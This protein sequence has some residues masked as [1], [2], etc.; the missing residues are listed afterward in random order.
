MGRIIRLRWAYFRPDGAI[1]R[2]LIAVAA[3][4][5]GQYLIASASWI[6]LIFLLGQ[7]SKEVTAGYTIAIRVMIFTILPCWGMANAAATLVGQNLGAGQP[8]R[9][10]RSA[11]RAGFFNL[12]FM[13][14][15]SLTTLITAPWIIRLFTTDPH[16]IEAGSLALRI[17]ASGYVFYG[18]GMIFG[19]AIN[20]AGDT[21]TPTLL[22]FIFFWLIETPL[23]WLLALGIGWGQVGVYS[24]IVLAESGLALA[25]MWV[26]SKGW[27]KKAKV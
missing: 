24:S 15:V 13:A 21:R 25:A 4:G 10:E 7:I 17:L 19:Q 11:W 18:Y 1:I 27:W 20:G 14:V 6:F 9:A 12:I 3:G 2:R 22:N 26:F 23:A 16:V 5:T 8:E